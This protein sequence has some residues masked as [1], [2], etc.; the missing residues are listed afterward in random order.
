MTH[1]AATTPNLTYDCDTHYP[2]LDVDIVKGGKRGFEDGTL[3]VPD[4]P[5]LGVEI[6][7]EA[8]A[9]LNTLYETS[10]VTDRDD[11]HEMRKYVPDYERK[12]PRW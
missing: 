8:L 4:R 3:T 10:G 9:S 7:E 1:L 12:V 2:W 11:T 6:D 5:G